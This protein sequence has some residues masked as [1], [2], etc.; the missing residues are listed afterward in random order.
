LSSCAARSVATRELRRYEQ[1]TLL[2]VQELRNGPGMAVPSELDL[3]LVS[4]LLE[5]LPIRVWIF[6]GRN[7]RRFRVRKR[8]RPIEIVVGVPVALFAELV[9]LPQLGVGFAVVPRVRSSQRRVEDFGDLIDLLGRQ[10][11]AEISAFVCFDETNHLL[12]SL[13]YELQHGAFLIPN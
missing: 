9:Q 5:R 8:A 3:L 7:H 10:L 13:V 12:R 1:R 11:L 6:A 4:Q 2:T